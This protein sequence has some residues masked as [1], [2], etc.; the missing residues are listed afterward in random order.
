[1]NAIVICYNVEEIEQKFLS[2]NMIFISCILTG[3][4]D[5]HKN[6][7]LNNSRSEINKNKVKIMLVNDI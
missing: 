5:V 7:Q 4:G 1:M 2:A 3:S 6:S